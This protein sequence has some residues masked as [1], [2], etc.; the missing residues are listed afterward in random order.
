MLF[1]W[2]Q[3]LRKP[4]NECVTWQSHTVRF[5]DHCI[6]ESS[7][8]KEPGT[9]TITWNTRDS[10]MGQ[11]YVSADGAEES[12]FAG[13]PQGSSTANWIRTGSSYRFRLYKGTD[14]EKLLAETTVTR[15]K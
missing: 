7:A 2:L 14:R 11:V 9:T 12:V 6:A 4:R 15:Q 5:N 10:T 8:C 3:A 13:A 1:R